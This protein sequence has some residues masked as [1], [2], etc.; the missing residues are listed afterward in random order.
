M[1]QLI[2]KIE[3]LGRRKQ[4]TTSGPENIETELQPSNTEE[5]VGVKKPQS[6]AFQG[7]TY[8]P[9]RRLM[10]VTIPSND[11]RE[12]KSTQASGENN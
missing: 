12:H 11:E 6:A 5:S 10:R 4:I 2:K 1:T 8:S 3:H 7:K 9:T